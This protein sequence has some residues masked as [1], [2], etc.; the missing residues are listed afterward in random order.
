MQAEAARCLLCEDPPCR[1]ACPAAIDPRTFIRKIRFGDLAGAARHLREANVLAGVCAELCPVEDLCV[2]ACLHTTLDRPIDIPGL[3]RHVCRWERDGGGPPV[4]PL[5]PWR[6]RIAV[7][8]AGPAGLAA[9][10]ELTRRG[11]A[12]TV[13]DREIE[14]G[15]LLRTMI[16]R[17]R[18]PEE[19]LDHDV[20]IVEAL[21]VDLRL[22]TP[23]AS[24]AA[25][26]AED[27]AAVLV[28]TGAA[29]PIPLR[30]PGEEHPRVRTATAFLRASRAGEAV[31]LGRRVA[32]VGGGDTA[33]DAA[34]E[35]RRLGAEVSLLYRRDREVMPAHAPE[36]DAA[37][38][39]GVE[40]LYRVMPLEIIPAPEP[41][42]LAGIRL[43]RVRWEA[44]GRAAR[45]YLPDGEPFLWPCDD[46]IVAA[47][48]QPAA[49]PELEADKRGRITH[50]PETLRASLP[51]I[52]VAGDIATGPAI[53]VGAIGTAKAAAAAID[54]HLGGET[55][56]LQPVHHPPRADL[57]VRFCG[58][59][60]E[61]PFLLAAA[62]PTDDL[63][64]LR[65]AFRAGWAGAVLKTTSVEGTA[66]PLAY[67]L[68]SGMGA[69]LGPLRA[70]G[71]ID[72]ISEH[73]VD[74][75]A[76]RVA[77]LKREFPGKVVAASIMGAAREEWE[78][79]V[80]RL[81]AAGVDW[82]ECSFSCPQGTLGSQPGAMLGQDA[83]LVREVAGWVK[84]A[85][86]RVPVVIKLTPQVADIG[87]IAAAAAAAGADGICAS[88]TIPAL[89]G[90]DLESGVPQPDLDGASTAS[91]LSGPA[92][93]PLTL[94]TLA[95]IAARTGLPLT[96]TGGP[97]TWRDAAACMLAGAGTV[98]FC[99]AVMHF[100]FGIV[101]D[102]RQGLAAYLDQRELPA[103]M[104]LVGAAVPR[105]VPHDALPRRKVRA[106]IDADLCIGDGRCYRACRDGGHRAIRIG[107]SRLP[108]I[109][110][111][112][113]V[114]CGLC[115]LV[116]PVPGCI[117]LV[118]PDD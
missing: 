114:G 72:L 17:A 11:F 108:E 41:A 58:I 1:D 35:A 51:G 67:P 102:L 80:Q 59:E 107:E 101:D 70:M 43:Q 94:R 55:R 12:V 112:R 24:P 47:G 25:L 52:F 110:P 109:D 116:C 87:A 34:R 86:Q 19:V 82:I 22:G 100:G 115:P 45:R 90:I 31:A 113:C 8:G 85:A 77:T 30:L 2:G 21:G 32:V 37:A 40:L 84:A 88:N 6:E 3:Q 4:A 74:V 20:S 78:T 111:D 48:L 118:T 5:T 29:E 60:F 95:S 98:Q 16:P 7:I 18:L 97:L 76:E 42:Q 92:I 13:Y 46:L 73:H 104:E 106:Q 96:A 26:L 14:A 103:A 69:P 71:N 62:P 105:V 33:I 28:A 53:A 75:V 68:M 36:V 23:V 66:V 65:D 10:A 63:E 99:T 44:G 64:M 56:P 27:Y 93:L 61:H 15:G 54:A 50:E 49:F 91:G 117:R 57:R 83:A 39:E 79:L 9:A 81:E 38:R 89:I